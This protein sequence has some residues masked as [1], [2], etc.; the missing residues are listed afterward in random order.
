MIQTNPAL[1]IM[2]S[3]KF[4]DEPDA[5]VSPFRRTLLNRCQ[6]EFFRE[7]TDREAV[8]KLFDELNAKSKNNFPLS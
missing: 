8:N 4:P 2:S 7:K 3:I 6:N 1:Q 5:K